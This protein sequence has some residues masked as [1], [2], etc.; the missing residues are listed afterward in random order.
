MLQCPGNPDFTHN[1]YS[2]LHKMEENK[3]ASHCGYAHKNSEPIHGFI[4]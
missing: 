1:Y 2:Y 3:Y 4:Y